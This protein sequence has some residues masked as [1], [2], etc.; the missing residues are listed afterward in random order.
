M[1][2]TKVSSTRSVLLIDEETQDRSL[3]AFMV[4][5]AMTGIGL[6]EVGSESELHG[7]IQ[8]G[9]YALVIT[10]SRTSWAQTTPLLQAIRSHQPTARVVV[11]TSED[12]QEIR[13]IAAE[14]GAAHYIVKS[15]EGFLN[16][17]ETAR[18]LLDAVDGTQPAAE[19]PAPAE[20]PIPAETP[21]PP[22]TPIPVETPAPAE[23]PIPA[24]VPAPAEAPVP[25][26][27]EPATES[28][29]WPD[30]PPA[31]DPSPSPGRTP[32]RGARWAL[33]VL[34]VIIVAALLMFRDDGSSDSPPEPPA[35]RSQTEP[36]PATPTPA[37]ALPEP[38]L[39]TSEA[40]IMIDEPSVDASQPA[41]SEAP[42]TLVLKANDEVWVGL[43][44]D[45]EQVLDKVL[46]AGESRTF[47]GRESASLRVGNAAGLSVSWNG[48]DLGSLGRPDQVRQLSFSAS[49]YAFGRRPPQ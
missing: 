31:V 33:I 41:E 40:P 11:F 17:V 45:G 24:D 23:A 13:S 49:G 16:L 29:P 34:A 5:S 15:S 25:A 32:G 47:S 21:A 36:A 38:T 48:Q 22:E 3:T 39:P 46:A 43:S 28:P 1:T 14:E 6:R 42:I 18:E 2:P 20:A 7:A 27:S 19:H 12:S 9:S 44:V 35:V 4:M 10:E 37:P 26:E 30:I 8:E